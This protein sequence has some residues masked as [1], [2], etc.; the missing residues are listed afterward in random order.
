MY[1]H[2]ACGGS[3]NLLIHMPAISHAATVPRMTVDDWSRINKETPRIVDVLPNGPVGFPTSELYSAGGVPE[4]MLHL[5]N[6]GV[7][8]TKVVTV[9]GQSLDANLDWWE[10]SRRR[11][12]VRKRLSERNGVDPADII[13]TPLKAKKKG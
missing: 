3:T 7:L 12:D 13:M 1:V 9:T 11:Y 8:D 5:R 4:I 2:A 10:N 6:M